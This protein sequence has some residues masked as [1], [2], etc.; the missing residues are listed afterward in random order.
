MNV[1]RFIARRYFKAKTSLNVIN[2]I[3]KISVGGIA[4]SV[5][6]LVILLSAFNGIEQMVIKLYSDFDSSLTIRSAKAK[7]FNQNFLEIENITQVKGV[8]NLS[9]AIEEVVIL[10]HEDKW[11]HAKMIGVDTTFLSMTKMKHHLVDGEA[12]LYRVDEPQAIFGA[13]LL[14]KLGGYIPVSEHL[15]E[16]IIFNA[17]LREG[18]IRPG[19]TPLNVRAVDVSARMNFNRE[20]NAESVVVPYELAQELLEYNEDIS[21]I[22]L[23]VNEKVN[24]NKVKKEVQA[25]VG[26]DFEV[27]THLE[28]NELIFK[29]S[30]SERLI[31]YFILVFIFILASFNLIASIVMLFVEKK[32]DVATLISIGAD[33]NTIRNIFFYEGLLIV[34][35]GAIIGLFI[36]YIVTFSQIQFGLVAMPSVPGESFPMFATWTDATLILFTVGLLGAVISYFPT[37]VL[38]KRLYL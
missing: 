34:A 17:P 8:I 32:N 31:I 3:S 19:K 23:E 7:T 16:Q 25:L 1:A 38:M 26:A 6:A 35:R 20:V 9:R 28:K 21:A 18:K 12:L 24:L 37:N 11:V 4:I 15:R 36:G 5:A 27:K 13:V 30:Q 2:L 22:Y 29:T 14:D 33:K 10:K